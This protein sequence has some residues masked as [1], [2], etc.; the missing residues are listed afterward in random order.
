MALHDYS[1][2]NTQMAEALGDVKTN[3]DWTHMSPEQYYS[4]SELVTFIRQKGWGKDVREAIAQGLETLIGMVSTGGDLESV[5]AYLET[6]KAKLNDLAFSDINLNYGKITNAMLAD[7]VI[8]AMAGT[9]EINAVP[10]DGVVTTQKLAEK[11]VTLSRLNIAGGYLPKPLKFYRSEYRRGASEN[12]SLK[13]GDKIVA[14][15]GI[16]FLVNLMGNTTELITKVF[17]SE[18][19]IP[20]DGIY[21]IT[22][23]FADDAPVTDENVI[24]F[25]TNVVIITKDTSAKRGELE[26]VATE[27]ESVKVKVKEFNSDLTSVAIPPVGFSWA[28]NPLKNRILTNGKGKFDVD[29]DVSE[30]KNTV[31]VSYYVDPVNGSDSNTGLT[32]STALSNFNTALNKADVGTI[33]ILNDV[34]RTLSGAFLSAIDKTINIIGL[35][36]VKIIAGDKSVYSKTD[37]YANVYHVKRAGAIRVIDMLSRGD[38]DYLELTKVS[39][40]AEVDSNENSWYSDGTNVYVHAKGHRVPDYNIAPLLGISNL[41]AKGNINLYLENIEFIG[42]ARPARFESSTGKLYAKNCQFKFACQSNGNGVEVVGGSLAIFQ[43][44]IASKN[45]MDGFNYHQSADGLNKPKFI[46]LHC[47]GRNN[48]QLKGTGGQRSDNGSTAHDGVVGIRVGGGR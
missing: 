45:M 30:L 36:D 25:D 1:Y 20:K 24:I 16:T 21:V 37:G 4:L 34:Y 42:G 12:T 8:K 35:G 23:K 29:F 18:Y 11:A 28:D 3:I 44:A 14:Y 46:E 40:I 31:G 39:S 9:A 2:I 22:A 7:E 48:G 26:T 27:L 33:Y 5:Q 13:A 19:E 43:N 10:A 47:T 15:D 41:L 6:L 32:K 38:E 17:V